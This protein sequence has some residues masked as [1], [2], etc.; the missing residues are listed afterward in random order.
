MF[1]RRRLD[2]PDDRDN[3][4]LSLLGVSQAIDYYLEGRAIWRDR[5]AAEV[6]SWLSAELTTVMLEPVSIQKS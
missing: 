1:P 4:R 3:I 5:P 2:S 6:L